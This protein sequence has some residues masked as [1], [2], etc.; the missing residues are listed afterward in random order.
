MK[1]STMYYLLLVFYLARF[2]KIMTRNRPHQL[3]FDPI[4][5]MS[6]FRMPQSLTE[7]L[8]EG[9]VNLDGVMTDMNDQDSNSVGLAMDRVSTLL[10]SMHCAY[11]EMIDTSRIH[12]IYRDDRA[13][14]QNLIDRIDQMIESLER[15]SQLSVDDTDALRKNIV[16][17]R[18]LRSKME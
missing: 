10:S 11:D 9:L 17:L 14:L 15:R 16:S 3:G 1:K 7:V 18:D 4:D 6:D 8:H 12:E 2:E 5:P 13:F